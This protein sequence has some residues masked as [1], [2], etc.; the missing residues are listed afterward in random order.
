MKAQKEKE[1]HALPDNSAAEGCAFIICL[2]GRVVPRGQI[3]E[4]GGGGEG[5]RRA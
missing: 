3:G 2:A 1:R 4:K 5:D